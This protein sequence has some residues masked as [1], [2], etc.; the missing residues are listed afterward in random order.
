M[1]SAGVRAEGGRT[2]WMLTPYKKDP[3]TP[4]SPCKEWDSQD[5]SLKEKEPR[6][7]EDEVWTISERN[8]LAH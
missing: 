8:D 5:D 4:S 3:I 7:R 1:T 6:I 2:L